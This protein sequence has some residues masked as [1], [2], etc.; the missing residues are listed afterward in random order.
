MKLLDKIFFPLKKLTSKEKITVLHATTEYP[1]PI[2]EVN[3]RA[4]QT[5]KTA[6][7]VKV[8]YSDHTQGSHASIAASV[9][10][11]K[12]IEKH[13]TLN[14]HYSNFRDHQLSLN[15][16]DMK[17]LVKSIRSIESMMGIEGKTLQADEKKNISSMRRSLYSSKILTRNSILISE[18]IRI[19][20][21]FVSL[22]PSDIKRVVGKK[23]KKNIN[24]NRP[25]F[26]TN[27]KK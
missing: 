15:P 7:G 2:G 17:S 1:C 19:V 3:L 14:N 26:L 12:I 10:G 8:G 13:F 9:I 22:G 24:I 21:P 25:I 18:D 4:M 20:R 5:I 16:N 23:I 27:L 11:A 6:F